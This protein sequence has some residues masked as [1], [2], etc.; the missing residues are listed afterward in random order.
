MIQNPT[1]NK[2]HTKEMSVSQSVENA[3]R[4]N[5]EQQVASTKIGRLRTTMYYTMYNSWLGVHCKWKQNVQRKKYKRNCTR[6][7]AAQQQ[8]NGYIYALVTFRLNV[9]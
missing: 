6:A 5:T 7:S 2:T 1:K 9:L 3:K 4:D 8:G